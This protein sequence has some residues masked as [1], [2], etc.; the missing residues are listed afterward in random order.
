MCQYCKNIYKVSSKHVNSRTVHPRMRD[1]QPHAS[2]NLLQH[3]QL[4]T[5]MECLVIAESNKR[6][7]APVACMDASD[8]SIVNPFDCGGQITS[9]AGALNHKG[10]TGRKYFMVHTIA[11]F[12]P[13]LI[14]FNHQCTLPLLPH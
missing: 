5:Y 9:F 13:P 3:H 14:H 10:I 4:L 7:L 8:Y 6:M 1:V 12:S 11:S 2:I